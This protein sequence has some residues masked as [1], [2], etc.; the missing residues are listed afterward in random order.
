MK[1]PH[2]ATILLMRFSI[3][4]IE[5]LKVIRPALESGDLQ[6]LACAVLDRWRPKQLC[7]LLRHDDS[8]VRRAGAVAIGITG[9]VSVV[10]SLARSLRDP[11]PQVH[12][13]VDQA[14]W[15]IW[16]RAGSGP[17]L[18]ALDRGMSLMSA[19]HHEDA[20]D[21]FTLAIQLDPGFVEAVNQRAI[22]R[23]LLGDWPVSLDDC[24]TVVRGMPWHFG[25]HAGMGHCR[26]QMGEV[27]RAL[28][29]Y[30]RALYINPRLTDIAN[31]LRDL[32][33]AADC[34]EEA[35]Y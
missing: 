27:P 11:D 2:P 21:A 16:F 5:F 15:K 30:R 14:M 24:R 26:L 34:P 12:A 8:D 17:A 32:G 23:Y 4:G 25:A 19:E 29:C 13:M 6:Q 35:A 3:D 20:V 22:A 33:L 1:I 31:A 10:C 9:D 7:G 28:R 18:E